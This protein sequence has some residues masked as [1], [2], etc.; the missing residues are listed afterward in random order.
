MKPVTL[1]IDISK[2]TFDVDPYQDE[3]YQLGHFSNDPVGFKKLTKWLAKRKAAGC[4]VCIEATGRYGQALALFL[5]EAGYPISVVNP[6]RI[7]A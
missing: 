6:A 7:K 4:H 3:Q 2:A 1:G 5:H